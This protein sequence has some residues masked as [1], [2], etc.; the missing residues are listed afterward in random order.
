[1]AELR[2]QPQPLAYAIKNAAEAI[3][4][5]ASLLEQLIARGDINPRWIKSKRVITIA[6]LQAFIDALPYDKPEP[7]S[8]RFA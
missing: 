5:S 7:S 1:M 8:E 3:G 6:E 2:T 4:I